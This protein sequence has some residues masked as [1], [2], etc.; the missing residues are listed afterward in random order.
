VASAC[1]HKFDAVSVY[2]GGFSREITLHYEQ[3]TFAVILTHNKKRT[4]CRT[5]V[6]RKTH[7]K[8]TKNTHICSMQY[9]CLLVFLA[10]FITAKHAPSC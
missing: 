7:K 6:D 8:H 10:T 3:P 2:Y 5:K 1:R 9:I 4:T